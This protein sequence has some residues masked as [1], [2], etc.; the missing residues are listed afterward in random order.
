MKRIDLELESASK[1][2][3]GNGTIL[4]K[5]KSGFGDIILR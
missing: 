4:I 3:F 5:A 1:L 2:T